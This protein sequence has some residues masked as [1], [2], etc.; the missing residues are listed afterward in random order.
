VETGAK[1]MMDPN[2]LHAL[3]FSYETRDIDFTMVTLPPG[4]KLEFLEKY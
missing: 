3:K 4:L 2:R 1:L